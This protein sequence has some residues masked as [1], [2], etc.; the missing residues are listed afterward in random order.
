MLLYISSLPFIEKN[1]NIF[2]FYFEIVFT[3][4]LCGML[5][6]TVSEQFELNNAFLKLFIGWI[7]LIIYCIL[8]LSIT[9]MLIFN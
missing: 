6:L 3:I 4:I 8:I 1:H 9:V 7:T 5:F 2:Y